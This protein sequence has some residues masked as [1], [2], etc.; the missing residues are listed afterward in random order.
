M[1]LSVSRIFYGVYYHS[2]KI[3]TFFDWVELKQGL[4]AWSGL[5]V[6]PD[7]DWVEPNNSTGLKP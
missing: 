3:L 5:L 1:T 7:T 4:I 6:R 2:S